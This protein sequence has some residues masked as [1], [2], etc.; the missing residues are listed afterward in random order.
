MYH[1]VGRTLPTAPGLEYVCGG[2]EEVLRKRIWRAWSLILV[3]EG[4]GKL[5]GFIGRYSGGK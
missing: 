1:D 5:E 4:T 3:V 2:L